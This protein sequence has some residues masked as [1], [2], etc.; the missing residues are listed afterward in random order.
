MNK[1]DVLFVLA[2][3]VMPGGFFVLAF[4]AGKRSLSKIRNHK[5]GD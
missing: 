1:K 4:I 2:M 3:M 5:M